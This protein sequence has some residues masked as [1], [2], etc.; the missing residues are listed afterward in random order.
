MLPINFTSELN[1]LFDEIHLVAE[2]YKFWS[3]SPSSSE[4]QQV[5]KTLK[6]ASLFELIQIGVQI[7]CSLLNQELKGVIK[8]AVKIHLH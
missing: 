6:D 3:T 4:I 5:I 1:R 7:G 2:L 8:G